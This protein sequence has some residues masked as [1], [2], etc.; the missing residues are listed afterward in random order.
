MRELAGQCL[1]VCEG[2]T[3][4]FEDQGY[5]GIDPYLLDER[6]F[7]AR[8]CPLIGPIVGKIRRLLK[9]LHS[10]IPQRAFSSFSPVIMPKALGLIMAGNASLYHIQENDAYLE[11]NRRLL[12]LLI[13]HRSPGF[14]HLCWGQPFAWGSSPRYPPHTPAVCVTSP[15]GH[16][17]LDYYEVSGDEEALKVLLDV[18][19]YLMFENGCTGFDQSLCLHYSPKKPNLTYNSNMMAAS[20]LMRLSRVTGDEEQSDFGSKA[21][22]FIL[23][24]QNA[25]GSWYYTDPRGKSTLNTMID[26]RHTG[27]ILE[28]LQ[29]AAEI[30][31]DDDVDRAIE[32][33]WE[34]YKKFL[35]DGVVPKWSP[36]R[37][38]PVDIHDVAQAIITPVRL[39]KLD[40]AARVVKFALDN[41]F[42]G[43][44]EFHYKLF[45]NGRVNPT[46]FIR[47]GQAWMF[48]ALSGFSR[49]VL[50][51]LGD[52]RGDRT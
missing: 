40:F 28:H 23:E 41:L 10:W 22:N 30:L 45:E 9:P 27:F 36:T 5:A 20:F 7:R 13:E 8:Q 43:H 12:E 49:E 18:S 34:Y 24:G 42:D 25:D 21:V 2:L 46:V 52:G 17:L 26:H 37:T 44:D 31:Q 4:W 35:F 51:L 15:I 29:I 48:K 39:G 3:V 32:R 1:K 19:D 38:Y 47:W 50:A 6:A 16:G 33:G 14:E 11:A